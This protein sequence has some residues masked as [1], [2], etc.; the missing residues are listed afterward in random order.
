MKLRQNYCHAFI[1]ASLCV[2]SF[3]AHSASINCEYAKTKVERLICG[4]LQLLRLDSQLNLVFSKAQN[5]TVGVDGETGA[6]SDPV[7]KEEKEWV[8]KV[9]NKC[10][11][12]SCLKSA[13]QNR[14]GQ[15]HAN[16]NVDQ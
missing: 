14:I 16:W 10:S 1:A 15:I 4:D 13:Y 5:E 12:I 3:S 11:N 2:A 7:G 9:R 6:R 8:I